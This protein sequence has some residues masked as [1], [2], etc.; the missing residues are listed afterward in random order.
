MD[1]AYVFQKAFP[2]ESFYASV[3]SL[4][5][6][7]CENIVYRADQA[8]RTPLDNFIYGGLKWFLCLLTG[9]CTTLPS[10]A[11]LLC[12][13]I[14]S[15]MC[16]RG[17]AEGSMQSS[18]E[19][20]LSLYLYPRRA[21]FD[22]ALTPA[23]APTIAVTVAAF[24]I[25]VN[26]GVEN[27]AGTKFSWTLSIMEDS[28]FMSFCV[29]ACFNC[30]LVVC[31]SS[32]VVFW[33]PAAAGSGIPDVKGYLNGIDVPGILH[34]RTLITKV[35]GCIC[36]VAG[37]LA[38]GKEGPFVHLGKHLGFWAWVWW[39]WDASLPRRDPRPVLETV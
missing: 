11:W 21:C 20:L 36:S 16:A 13:G 12:S 38:V 30:M 39:D 18:A 10:T 26:V 17:G 1:A 2:Q 4:D 19:Q 23:S 7:V 9:G 24:G 3:E 28:Y 29:Y 5:Y 27:L 25:I 37:G 14:C 32:M 6:D 22:A 34:L 33:G 15:I 35:I 31:A 8:V